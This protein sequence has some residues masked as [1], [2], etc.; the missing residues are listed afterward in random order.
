MLLLSKWAW[1]CGCAA[2]ITS[3]VYQVARVFVGKRRNVQDVSM[4]FLS[5]E[6]PPPS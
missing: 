4:A 3:R 1:G 6:A 2:L 5:H